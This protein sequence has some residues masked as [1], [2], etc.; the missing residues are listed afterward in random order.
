M[1]NDF[2]QLGLQAPLLQ[3]TEDLGYTDPTPIQIGVIPLMLSGQDVIGQ[4]QTG[5]GKTAAFALPILQ[6]LEAG[7][8]VPQAL[9]LA[10]TRELAMQV[11]EA[12]VD[13]GRHLKVRVLAVYGGQAYGPQI[14]QL[15][16]GVDVVVGTPGRLMD[17]IDRKVLDLKSVTCVVLD[18]ADEMLSMGFIDDIESI[19]QET[20]ETRQ[21]TL[22]SATLPKQIRHLAAR[23]LKDPQEVTIERKQLTVEAIEQR[24]YLVNER[25]KS[26]A[27][28][29][30]FE[31]EEISSALIFVR[32]RA[33]TSQLANELGRRG[34]PAEALSGELEQ[35]ARERVLER[36]RQNQ[37]KVLVATDVAARGLDIDDISHVF[38]YDL[39]EDPEIYVHRIG[40]T[41]R[42]G[43]SGTAISLINPK[44]TGL[45]RRIEG[46]TRQQVRR[47]KLP[48]LEE[49]KEKREDELLGQVR[50]W[51]QRGRGQRERQI[52][53]D[54]MEE[55]HDPVDIATAAL[56]IARAEE[57]QRPIAEIS[58]V[59]ERNS[60]ASNRPVRQHTRRKSSQRFKN[61]T[62]SHEE[63]MVRMTLSAG[64]SQGIRPNDVV[65]AIA[66]HADI[67]GYSIGAIHIDDQQT[68]VD[69]PE[70][71]VNKVL[72][73]N[74]KYKIRRQDIKLEIA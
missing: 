18:E 69:V 5:T 23:Y 37:I 49:I 73:R 41:G 21:T 64:K 19:L 52:I 54:L 45:L 72:A 12:M 46:F 28:A 6:N 71:F 58:E 66:F 31:T 17:L 55:G 74:G 3:A 56:K 10:P 35:N 59:R 40:R 43:K 68:L 11:A 30:L 42:A 7:Q 15:K 26:A 50:I 16:K 13:Y 53:L 29:R 20:P 4:A 47:V 14:G 44:Q 62:S 60:S 63:G 32:T 38:N 61:R 65:G 48:T 27:L 1:T 22:F 36:F 8:R 9:V 57:K 25:D 33:G 70:K 67:P 24:H 2:T 51:L 34:F 39:P